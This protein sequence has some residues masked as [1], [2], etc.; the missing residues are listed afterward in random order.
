MSG[1]PKT[2]RLKEVIDSCSLTISEENYELMYNKII[3]IHA[4]LSKLR[5][6]EI[7]KDTPK[8]ETDN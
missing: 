4:H 5:A 2:D 1:M 3:F 7:N 8:E 6:E